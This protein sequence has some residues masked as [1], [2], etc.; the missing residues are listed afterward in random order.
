MNLLIIVLTLLQTTLGIRSPAFEEGKMI[1]EDYTCQGKNISPPLTITNLPKKTAS[2]V[3]ILDDPDA[4]G[5]G[6][7]HWVVYNIPPTASI[8]EDY[9][10]GVTANN[11]K[12]DPQYTGPCPPGGSGI[13][14]YH[15]K[16]Y[17]LDVKLDTIQNADET[18]VMDKMK[19]HIL[20]SGELV[21]LYI[22]D[23]ESLNK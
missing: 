19:G 3:V 4:A 15:F 14:H 1:P 16:V 13:H 2:M 18:K 21:G 20:A 12:G 11:G 10:G 17:A 23:N 9:S 8:K 5:G 6:F 7:N 22:K